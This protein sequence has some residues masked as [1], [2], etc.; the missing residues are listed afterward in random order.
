MREDIV[1]QI[2]VSIESGPRT[3]ETF[4]FSKQIITLGR[5]R[6]NDVP[7]GSDSSVSERHAFVSW[8]EGQW[9]IEDRSSKNGIYLETGSGRKRLKG[10]AAILPD[11]I[12]LLGLTM[13]KFPSKGEAPIEESP[14]A[15]EGS[16]LPCNVLKVDVYG[17]ELVYQ[18]ISSGACAAEYNVPYTENDV[19]IIN[20]RLLECAKRANILETA[21]TGA[22]DTPFSEPLR[23]AGDFLGDHLVPNRLQEKLLELESEDLLLIHSAKLTQVPWELTMIQGQ[24]MCLRFNLGRQIVVQDFTT[25]FKKRDHHGPTRVLI[26]CN[27]T[28]DLREA[29]RE[30]EGLFNFIIDSRPDWLVSYLGGPRVE[31]LDLLT[32]LNETDIVYF[33]GHAEYDEDEPSK[34]GWP[35]NQGKITCGDLNKLKHPP[36]LVFANGCETGREASWNTPGKGHAAAHGFATGFLLAGVDAYIGSV[37]PIQPAAGARYARSVFSHLFQNYTLGQAVRL[38]RQHL[39]EKHPEDNLAWASYLLYGDPARNVV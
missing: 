10:N 37:W 14:N 19:A 39:R 3:G 32:R 7:L 35:L 17:K 22:R 2:I 5:G 27:P 18:L 25:Q 21:P 38:G 15:V 28:G 23:Q 6:N 36:R 29:Q 33:L 30:T 4:T 1:P 11:H 20:E 26:I 8:T 13:V 34:S 31:R 24:F 9:F 16:G 12:Y